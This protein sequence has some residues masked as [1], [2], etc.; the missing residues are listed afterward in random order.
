MKKRIL[1]LTMGFLYLIILLDLEGVLRERSRVSFLTETFA[2]QESFR[3][4]QL[5]E[6]L[7]QKIHQESDGDWLELL[8]SSMADGHFFPEKVTASGG[9]YRKY[10]P[11]EYQALKKA[12]QAVWEDI[13]YFPVAS[14]DTYFEDTWLSRRDYGGK[15]FHEGTDIFGKVS[16][17]GYYPVVSMTDGTVEKKGWLPLGGYRIGIRAPHGGYFYYAHLSSYEKD[18]YPGETVRAGDILGYMG[19]TGYGEEGTR[20]RFP[21]HLHLGI[22]V[23]T[24]DQREISVNPYW[25][26]RNYRK[27]IRNYIY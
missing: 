19:N 1:F 14:G 12:Y 7:Y 18:F 5:T 22:Y 4:Q 13:R 11:D 16:V 17:S 3:K 2:E 10:K 9:I 15:R 27:K 24:E 26:L 23:L 6:K 20:G 8:T 25:V 21:V